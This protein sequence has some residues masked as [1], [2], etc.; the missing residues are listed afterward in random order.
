M[1]SSMWPFK[2]KNAREKLTFS[3]KLHRIVT[4]IFVAA[5]GLLLFKLVPMVMWGTT[6][7]FDASF[8]VT[9][10]TLAMYVL[11]FFIDQNPKWRTPFFS[12]ATAVVLVVAIQRLLVDAHSDIG[13]LLALAV[14]VIAIGA[15][16]WDSIRGK[17]SF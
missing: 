1:R 11:W 7:E 16:E 4:S 17:I 8:H 14:G 6:I 13:I 2:P 9:A 10:V 12:I 15:A 5:V 3:Q